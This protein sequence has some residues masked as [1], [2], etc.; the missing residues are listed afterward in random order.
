MHTSCKQNHAE[1]K[2]TTLQFDGDVIVQLLYEPGVEGSLPVVTFY[3]VVA[4]CEV[5]LEISFLF[6]FQ[7]LEHHLQTPKK[8]LS[9]SGKN[10]FG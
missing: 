1:I 10:H 8:S 5:R 7:K 2:P 3:A 6:C 9:L 4:V